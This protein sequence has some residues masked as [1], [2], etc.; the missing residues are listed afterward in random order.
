MNAEDI[1]RRRREAHAAACVGIEDDYL[2]Q[3]AFGRREPLQPI[4][5]T[6]LYQPGMTLRRQAG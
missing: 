3:V 4:K 5:E 1:L 2:I 6:M